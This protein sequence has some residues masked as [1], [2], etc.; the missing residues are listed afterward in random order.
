MICQVF[1]FSAGVSVLLAGK[2]NQFPTKLSFIDDKK[3]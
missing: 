3:I 2:D 1:G